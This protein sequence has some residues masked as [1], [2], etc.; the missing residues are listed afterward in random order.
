MAKENTKSE[1]YEAKFGTVLKSKNKAFKQIQ[2]GVE[3]V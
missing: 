3:L 1:K 2:I